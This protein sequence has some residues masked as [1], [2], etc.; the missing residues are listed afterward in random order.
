MHCQKSDTGSLSHRTCFFF[1]WSFQSGMLPPCNDGPVNETCF[2]H[3]PWTATAQAFLS[4]A[5]G[6]YDP[7]YAFH[8]NVTDAMHRVADIHPIHLPNI[9]NK[10]VCLCGFMCVRGVGKCLLRQS[11]AALI[12]H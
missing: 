6:V 9:T 3:C 10:C 1:P 11:G 8:A 5:E 4:G 2:S 7:A 12:G